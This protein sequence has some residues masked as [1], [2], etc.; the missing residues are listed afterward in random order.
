MVVVCGGGH[1]L[2]AHPIAILK[3]AT[4]QHR[5]R[6]RL[7]RTQ[8]H[9]HTLGGRSL[10]GSTGR[11]GRKGIRRKSKKCQS[12]HGW[13]TNL[14]GRGLHRGCDLGVDGGVPVGLRRERRERLSGLALGLEPGEL[15]LAGV[16]DV[17]VVSALVSAW[18]I[19]RRSASTQV[20]IARS[21]QCVGL[22]G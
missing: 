11:A 14:G 20:L 12:G 3:H 8:M 2:A 13:R 1:P 15:V 4:P 10:H 5:A 19:R 16:S 17:V 6:T 22:L 21:T 18:R 7:W 9:I